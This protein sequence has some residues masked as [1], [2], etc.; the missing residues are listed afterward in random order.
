MDQQRA[1]ELYRMAIA[2]LAALVRQHGYL[3]SATP[4]ERWTKDELINEVLL[5]EAGI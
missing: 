2:D 5:L 1:R 4:P 3:G